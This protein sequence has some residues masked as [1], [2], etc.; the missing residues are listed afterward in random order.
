MNR[1]VNVDEHTRNAI[2]IVSQG[3]KVTEQTL[4]FILKS[5]IKFLEDDNKSKDIVISDNTKEGKQKIKDLIKKHKSNV[6]SLDEN[7]TKEQLK[8]YQREFKKLG[9]D[10]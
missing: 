3:A 10:F 2:E 7:L 4:L 5:I 1:L 9:V 6:Y 8:D